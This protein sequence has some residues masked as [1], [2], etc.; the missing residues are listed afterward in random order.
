MR[1]GYRPIQDG[2]VPQDRTW[3][4]L[5]SPVHTRTDEP[6]HA[7]RFPV[8]PHD[9]GDTTHADCRT[10]PFAESAAQILTKQLVD[11]QTLTGATYP[12]SVPPFLYS[13]ANANRPEQDHPRQPRHARAQPSLSVTNPDSPALSGYVH[14]PT[15]TTPLR[16]DS[17]WPVLC[18]LHHSRTAIQD[19]TDSRHYAW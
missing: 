6:G 1:V 10:G 12:Y 3:T 11:S 9:R 15:M 17:D 5:N 8:L 19:P 14:S 7:H 13:R 4:C 16:P 2:R 18:G